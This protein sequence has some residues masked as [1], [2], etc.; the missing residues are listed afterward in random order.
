M[1]L[2]M[3][4]VILGTT[5]LYFNR[6]EPY[7][8]GAIIATLIT[9][10][11]ACAYWYHPFPHSNNQIGALFM[12]VPTV[13]LLAILFPGWQ[14]KSPEMVNRSV[15]WLGLAAVIVVYGLRAW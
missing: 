4:V 10:V 7:E 13:S 15:G 12:L 14:S 2:F 3:I 11:F 1:L 5:Y 6:D 8:W 9:A